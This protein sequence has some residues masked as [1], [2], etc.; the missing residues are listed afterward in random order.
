MFITNYFLQLFRSSAQGDVQQLLHAVQPCVTE[1]MNAKLLAESTSGEI[2]IALDN[3]G[4]L[5]APGPDGM[6]AVFYK[7]FWESVGGQITSEVLAFLR[8]GPMPEKWN[9]TFIAL[10]PKVQM[11]ERVTDLRPISLCNVL[12][13]IVLGSRGL[14]LSDI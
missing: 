4:D 7:K 5:K 9:E 8:G 6:P 2:K 13:K 1:E 11:P 14:Q 3:I 12:Y 10:I